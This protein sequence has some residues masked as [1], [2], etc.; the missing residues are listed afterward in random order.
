MTILGR[1]MQDGFPI[2]TRIQSFEKRLF[3]SV[4]LSS[5]PFSLSLSLSDSPFSLPTLFLSS[6]TLSFLPLSPLS[7]SP[8]VLHFCSVIGG[9]FLL[10]TLIV[11]FHFFAV[12]LKYALSMRNRDKNNTKNTLYFQFYATT[13]Y[14]NFIF[15]STFLS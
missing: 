3:F 10:L 11:C 8:S 1:W 6:L 9:C 2:A 13:C 5:P 15:F 12:A 7:Y 14:S 4:S